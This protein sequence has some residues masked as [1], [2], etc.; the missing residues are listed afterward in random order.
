MY[1]MKCEISIGKYSFTQCKSVKIE[2]STEMLI[3]TAIIEL[4]LQAFVLNKSYIDLNKEIK[5]G[6]KVEIKLGYNNELNPEF[7]GFVKK[8]VVK[9][10]LQ[11]ECEDLMYSL[12]VRLD[13]KVFVNTNLKEVVNYAIADTEIVLDNLP[14]IEFDKFT[15]YNNNGIDVISNLEN[16]YGL[17]A[18]FTSQNKLFV[19]LANTYS[20]GSAVYDLQRNI[21]ANN[22]VYMRESDRNLKIK[23]VSIQKDNSRLEVDIGDKEGE[24]RT[25]YFS[26]IKDKKTL[27]EFAEAEL[28]KLIY[29]GFEGDFT[30]FLRPILQTGMTCKII[31]NKIDKGNYYVSK[32]TTTFNSS[33]GRRTGTLGVKL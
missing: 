16:D 22:L 19:G 3:D 28:R 21:I 14:D 29:N 4:P 6:N 26:N 10:F 1:L 33:G 13:N 2:H 24:Q 8:T 32:V 23:A 17:E 25:L 31:D 27:T 9:D 11:I 18:F 20:S 7:V 5:R 12:A 30:A 15:V